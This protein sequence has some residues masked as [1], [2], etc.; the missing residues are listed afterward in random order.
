ML[1]DYDPGKN[2]PSLTHW[3]IN[4]ELPVITRACWFPHPER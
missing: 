3:L 1:Q 4:K 2:I